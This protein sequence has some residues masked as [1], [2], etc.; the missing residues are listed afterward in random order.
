MNIS[1]SNFK[2]IYHL[3]IYDKDNNTGKVYLIDRFKTDSKSEY[4]ELLET[5]DKYIKCNYV[6][7]EE[8][9]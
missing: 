6:T 4:N 1:A 3:D 5:Y 9:I 8:F 7:L 2:M